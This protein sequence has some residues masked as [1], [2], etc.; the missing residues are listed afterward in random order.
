[1]YKNVIPQILSICVIFLERILKAFP[2]IIHN[3]HTPCIIFTLRI[4]CLVLNCLLSLLPFIVGRHKTIP[5][6]Q[7]L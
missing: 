6:E 7:R 5:R 2:C 3:F 4:Y 1:M